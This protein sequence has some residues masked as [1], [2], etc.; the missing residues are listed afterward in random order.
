MD[1]SA[2]VS[3]P[4]A[5]ARGFAPQA[6]QDP[7]AGTSDATASSFSPD[8]D[9]FGPDGSPA[10]QPNPGNAPV[11]ANHD[12]NSF[13]VLFVEDEQEDGELIVKSLKD[14]GIRKI[15]W[16]RAAPQ[17]YF[18]MVEDKE[19]FPDVLIIELA[20][21][22]TN[23]L[24]FL[25]RLRAD[26]DPAIRELPAIA[27]TSVDT[28]SIFRRATNQKICGY[29]RKPVSVMQLEN[30]LI[31]ARAKKVMDMP[32][33][34]GRSWIDDMEDDEDRAGARKPKSALQRVLEA[35][36]GTGKPAGK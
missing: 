9:S 4:E 18:Q 30:A 34:V 31:N 6:Y 27:V 35:I 19:M 14:V 10:P 17:A 32:L 29:V 7:F 28:A 13:R 23:G 22:G 33:A 8:A 16:V 36:F 5:Y 21:A 11:S 2:N 26:A 24:Q 12:W 20:L 3:R 1:K 15:T 25:A